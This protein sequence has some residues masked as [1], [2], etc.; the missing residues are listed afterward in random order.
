MD[1]H[2]LPVYEN[3]QRIIDSLSEHR[4]IVVESPT[5]SGKTTQLPIILHNAGFSEKG[6]LGVTQPRRI[7]AVSVSEYIAEQLGSELPGMVGYKMRFHDETAPETSIK[8]MTDGILLQELKTD[9][10]LSAY[11]TIIVDEAH[12]RSLNIDFSLGL[13]KR[14]LRSRDDF[15]VVVSSATI[16]AELFSEYFDECP[17]VR[18]DAPMY[19]VE[20]IYRPPEGTADD[21]SIVSTVN[22]VMEE[23]TKSPEEGDVLIFLTGEKQ[24]KMCMAKLEGARYGKGLH[25]L[26]LYGRLSK[27]EQDRVF[28][29]PPRGKRKVV[30]ATNIAETSIT[31]DGIRWVIDSGLAKIN[32]YNPKTFTASLI[33]TPISRASCN[34]RKGRAGRTAPGVCYRLYTKKSYHKRP[35]FSTE[36][37]Y[38]TDLSE[39]ILRMSEL[40]IRDFEG[41]DFL[42]PPERKDIAGAVE[43]LRMIEAI[44]ED[45]SLTDIGTMMARFPLLPRHSRIIVEAIR[46]YPG[47]IE[48]ALIAASFLSAK[49]PFLLPAG[50]EIEARKRHHR[51]RSP[52]GD[53]VS[54]L[55]MISLYRKAHNKLRFCNEHYL[56]DRVM[57]EIDNISEQLAEIVSEIGVPLEGGGS[58]SDYLCAVATGLVQFVCMRSGKGIYRSLT[59]ERIQIHP[60]SVMFRETPKYIVA[61]EIVRTS[62][63][64]ARSVSPLEREW[65]PKISPLLESTFGGRGKK[66]R[67]DE[68]AKEEKRDTSWQLTI[69]SKVFEL[70]PYKG[71][72]K[73]AQ[74]PWDRL[75]PLVKNDRI[76]SWISGRGLRGVVYYRGYELMTGFRLSKMFRIL[77]AIHPDEH[78]IDSDM[79]TSNM[80]YPDDRDRLMSAIDQIMCLAPV[81]KNSSRLG[82][83]SLNTD[84]EVFWLK[85]SK[86]YGHAVS[87]S[88]AA[89]ESLVDLL[90]ENPDDELESKANT[91]YRKLTDLFDT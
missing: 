90:S 38:R 8:V 72:K 30:I 46:S 70:K 20:V 23:I 12:E 66:K 87:E 41:F 77:K 19:P 10:Y 35:L 27:E 45:H 59:A 17:I 40:G 56:D 18:I 52:K 33:E 13:L 47:V 11:S 26:P 83:I 51:F 68:G 34:Q 60:G 88:L 67:S 4:T 24:I 49:S 42:S 65:I 50:E 84:G 62:R 91:V 85:S 15:R 5:G 14:I 75:G 57:S 86:G 31:I 74:L 53:F 16:N 28:Y 1:P 44:S 25:I 48:E 9:P 36:E 29:P 6:V 21:E 37:V 63:M 22:A 2:N 81:K 73:I 55:K 3:K 80:I 61:G 79:D 43:T 82:F 58:I 78:L 64:F 32:F 54:Y 76:P 71:K 39:V 7:A 69:D 89:I